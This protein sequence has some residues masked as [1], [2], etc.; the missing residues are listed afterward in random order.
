MPF[1][2]LAALVVASMSA[3]LD[4]RTVLACSPFIQLFGSSILLVRRKLDLAA[5]SAK[6]AQVRSWV[7]DEKMD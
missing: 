6:A 5:A 4:S 3:S 7:W 1:P 2:C